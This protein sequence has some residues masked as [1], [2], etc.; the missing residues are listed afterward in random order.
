[1]ESIT[2][3][4]AQ[5]IVYLDFDGENT[6]YRNNDLNVSLDVNVGNSFMSDEQ[7][8]YILSQLNEMYKHVNL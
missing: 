2:S 7:K 6:I 8:L 5:Q 1:M 3:P 4:F